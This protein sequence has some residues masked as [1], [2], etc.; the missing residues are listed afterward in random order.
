MTDTFSIELLLSICT[1]LG[2]VYDSDYVSSL[3]DDGKF[4]EIVGYLLQCINIFL[5]GSEDAQV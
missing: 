2:V 3:S 1:K 5:G 4:C